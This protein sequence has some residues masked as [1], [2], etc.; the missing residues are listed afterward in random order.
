MFSL[1]TDNTFYVGD[2]FNNIG[3]NVI[4]RSGGLSSLTLDP[5]GNASFYGTTTA[6]SFIKSGGTSTQFLKADGSI[7]NTIYQPLLNN[8]VTGSLTV[9]YLPKVIGTTILGNSA[10]QENGSLVSLSYPST[11]SVDTRLSI[12][13]SGNGGTG[14]GTAIVMGVPGSSSNV[15]GVKINAYTVGGATASQSAD[16]AFDVA[17]SGVL[18][19]RMRMTS[20]GNLLIGKTA[21]DNVNKLQVSGTV[22]SAQYKL[23][24]LNTAPD[25]STAPGTLGEIRFDENYMY[26]C[27]ATNTW[28][29]CP[30]TTW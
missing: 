6:T 10:I 30:L 4:L 17:T 19:E 13:N 26:V 12:S 25:S 8:P 21:D 5:S 29:R 7:D 28:K 14:R 16:L 3:G 22:V 9:G 20:N 23:S 15:E 24:A 2:I 1:A 11:A 27:V 18:T